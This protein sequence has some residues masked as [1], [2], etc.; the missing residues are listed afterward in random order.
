MRILESLSDD[1][2]VRTKVCEILSMMENEDEYTPEMEEWFK[3]RTQRH[4]NLVR[5]YCMKIVNYDPERFEELL[6]RG[7]I[8]DQS[9]LEEPERTPYIYVSWDYKCKDDGVKWTPPK[10]I[11]DQMNQATQHHVLNN[12]H[13]PEFHQEKKVDL[14]NREDRDKPPKEMVDATKMTDLDIG[15]MCADWLAMSEEKGTSVKEWAD[16][17]V[18]IRWKFTPQQKSLIYEILEKVGK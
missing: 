10:D 15:E 7:S 16:K 3:K 18:N 13:H 1:R 2:K 11:K 4:I 17:N 8:H 5:K 6:D 9:K 12:P 14:I